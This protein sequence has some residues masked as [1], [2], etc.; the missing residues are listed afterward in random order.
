MEIINAKSKI[1]QVTIYNTKA[2][3]VRSTKVLAS[4]EFIVQFQNLPAYIEK[5]SIQ[6]KIKGNAVVRDLK[7]KEEFF[8]TFPDQ[9]MKILNEEEV[10]ITKKKRKLLDS[11]EQNNLE[12]LFLEK[13]I[14]KISSKE[15]K[16]EK[17]LDVSKWIQIISFYKE[18]LNDLFEEKRNLENE[19]Y[20]VDNELSEIKNKISKISSGRLKV[21]NIV[22]LILKSSDDSEIEIEL[23]YLVHNAGWIPSYDI[24]VNSNSKTMN[25]TYNAI[26]R[27]NTAEDWNDVVIKLSTAKPN[28]SGIQPE[29]IP[30]RLS[31]ANPLDYN[32]KMKRRS[33]SDSVFKMTYAQSVRCEEVE[34]K[35]L[36]IESADVENLITSTT[37]EVAG[38]SNIKSDNLDHKVSFLISDLPIEFEYSSVPKMGQYAYLRGKTKNTTGYP[39][40]EGETNIYLDNCFI[41]NANMK[42]VA[43]DEEFWTSLGIDETI[44]I[45]YKFIKKTQSL[46]GMFNKQNKFIYEY[47]ITITNNK[48]SDE[49]VKI[50][51]QL[52][53][54]ENDK[55]KINLISP[56]YKENTEFLKKNELNFLEWILPIKSKEK[57]ELNLKFS[58][59]YP[60]NF[61]IDGID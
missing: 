42:Y 47:K 35:E 20:D 60:Q 28:I 58:I 23:L 43:D 54:S 32:A 13:I 24:R 33:L 14:D 31:L 2:H 26:V 56:E 21:K 48:F 36:K 41:A 29:L 57:I 16:F 5:T 39:Y 52:P 38:T 46:D 8:Q 53:I 44:K 6:A 51:D 34:E 50:F 61:N 59:E 7:F 4:G 40:L 49:I 55:I 17:T 22:E 25:I 3:I 30:W 9:D 45:D 27:Q 1:T 19:L 18:K 10:A 37:F 15:N 11:I 12:K